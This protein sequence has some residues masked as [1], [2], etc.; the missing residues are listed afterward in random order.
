MENIK[1]NFGKHKG[2]T[3]KQL[4]EE[5]PHYCYYLY[6]H[7]DPNYIDSPFNKTLE[8]A[9]KNYDMKMPF[10]KKHKGKSLKKL[11]KDYCQW[12]LENTKVGQED[13]LLRYKI[14]QCLETFKSIPPSML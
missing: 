14:E 12:L 5:K 8:Q 1:I 7:C 4:I 13:S 10:G 2:L 6:S 3:L 9:I 11:P